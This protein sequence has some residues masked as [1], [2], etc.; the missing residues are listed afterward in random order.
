MLTV[1]LF[2]A[3][4]RWKH[5]KYSPVFTWINIEIVIDPFNGILFSQKGRASTCNSM[6]RPPK[7]HAKGKKSGSKGHVLYD[8]VYIKFLD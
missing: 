7:H 1:A 8:S 5:P 3:V 4:K 6:D 2:T